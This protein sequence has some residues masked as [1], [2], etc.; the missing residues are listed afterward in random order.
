M[1]FAAGGG[2]PMNLQASPSAPDLISITS[3]YPQLPNFNFGTIAEAVGLLSNK[4][5]KYDFTLDLFINKTDAE[6]TSMIGF[7]VKFDDR[8][9]TFYAWPSNGKY[10]M[11]SLRF[12]GTFRGASSQT[13]WGI[14]L[15]TISNDQTVNPMT[16][17]MNSLSRI[18]G[19]TF[20]MFRA[21]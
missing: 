5:V 17:Y 19:F 9:N 3:S 4:G 11:V 14:Y 1:S 7:K 10:S 20:R 12:S 21:D 18:R 6:S 8:E 2:L 15:A 16:F 13:S